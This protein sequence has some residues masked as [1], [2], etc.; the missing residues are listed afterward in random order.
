[1]NKKFLLIVGGVIGAAALTGLIVVL[2]IMFVNIVSPKN[3]NNTVSDNN[4]GHLIENQADLGSQENFMA[5]SQVDIDI[6][7]NSYAHKNI[8]IKKDTVVV[9]TNTDS[10]QHSVM[11]KDGDSAGHKAPEP[12]EVRS[13]KFTSALLK[14]GEKYNFTFNKGGIYNYHCTLHDEELG[15]ISVLD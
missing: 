12:N 11:Q 8:R 4:N 15:R 2:V 9:W 10:T 13:D 5:Q 7:K 6:S 1:M 3:D 14:K